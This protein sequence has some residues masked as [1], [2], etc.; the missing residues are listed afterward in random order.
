VLAELIFDRLWTIK[1][2]RAGVSY[3]GDA[4]GKLS[5]NHDYRGTLLDR[6]IIGQR[7][8]LIYAD[9]QYRTV[10]GDKLDTY[11]A[12]WIARSGDAE[13]VATYLLGDGS[14][15]AT[16]RPAFVRASKLRAAPALGAAVAAA[17]ARTT[18][19]T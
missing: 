8:G 2:G 1:N 15:P 10:F 17:Q 13:T 3:R 19:Q 18:P 9:P 14:A 16:I 4:Y 6:V 12:A 5:P 7:V 11:L